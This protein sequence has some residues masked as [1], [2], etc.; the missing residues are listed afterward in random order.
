MALVQHMHHG[1]VIQLRLNSALISTKINTEQIQKT[2]AE[3]RLNESV[4]W[5]LEA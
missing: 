3:D 4:S 5:W 2:D 1:K